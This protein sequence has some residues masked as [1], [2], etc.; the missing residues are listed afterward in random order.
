MMT[1]HK[2]VTNTLNIV[3]TFQ[4]GTFGLGI[5][6]VRSVCNVPAAQFQLPLK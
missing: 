4:S 2:Y 5:T 1:T 3:H 6:A